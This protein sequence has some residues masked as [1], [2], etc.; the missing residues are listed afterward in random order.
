MQLNPGYRAR[1]RGIGLLDGL[2]ALAILGF[3]LLGMTRMQISVVKQASDSQA[4]MT[5]ATLGDE[6]LSTALVDLGNANCYTRPAVGPC[7]SAAAAATAAAWESRVAAALPGAVSAA[8][9]RAG[10]RLTVT[11]AWTGKTSPSNEPRT[12]TV[13]TDARE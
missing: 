11:I 5:A 7:T 8:S 3:G 9:V 2:I 6:L 13:S 4:R 12:L 1:S 10:D